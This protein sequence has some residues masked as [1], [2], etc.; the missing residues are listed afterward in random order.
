MIELGCALAGAA[1]GYGLARWSARPIIEKPARKRDTPIVCI[2]GGHG[3]STLLRGLKAH[4]SRLTAIVTVTDDGGSSGRLRQEYRV[5][6]P[7]DIRNCLAALA[8]RDDLIARLF[9][10]R[11]DGAGEL[12]GH[13]L[14]N[15]LLTG[16]GAITGNFLEAIRVSGEFLD[17]Q[18][19]V[20]PS[21]LQPVGLWAVRPD[22]KVVQGESNIPQRGQKIKELHLSLDDPEPTP[23]VLERIREAELIVVGPG[24]L[25]TSILPNLLVPSIRK[26]IA[27]AHAPVLVVMNVMTQPGETDDFTVGD[28]L[29]ALRDIGGLSRVHRVL[30]HEGAPSRA[31]AD[32][33]AKVGA[34]PV[35][36]DRATIEALG[37]GV[38]Q[39]DV[40]VGPDRF[41]HDPV[42]LART[43]LGVLDDG[44]VI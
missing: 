35:E 40:L 24:S 1:L 19:E 38:V 8:A 17:I 39:A 23:G 14:G 28:H 43:I 12:S 31:V 22:G 4:T 42:K 26:A 3:L 37:E 2:G 44:I 11:F 20:L 15:L 10:F 16:L 29:T 7:G 6:P 9:Q 36:L 18:G 33:S 5:L 34:R 30:V 21:T 25:Y 27:A 32:R 13:S 41:E